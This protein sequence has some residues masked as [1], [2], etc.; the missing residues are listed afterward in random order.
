VADITA[1]GDAVNVTARF[2]SLAAAGEVL[3]SEYAYQASG[4]DLGEPQRRRVELKGRAAP[5]EVRVL[6]VGEDQAW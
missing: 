5:M 4:L 1:I 6:R 2:S 3:V